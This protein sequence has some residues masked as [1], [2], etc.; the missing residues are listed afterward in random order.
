MSKFQEQQMGGDAASSHDIP[1]AKRKRTTA[2][3]DAC[4]A[5]NTKD[6]RHVLALLRLLPNYGQAPM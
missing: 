6:A 5:Q 2:Q 4:S 3:G 1:V